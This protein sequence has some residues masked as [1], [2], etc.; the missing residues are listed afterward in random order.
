MRSE[1]I[2]F[3]GGRSFLSG[4][5]Y[6]NAIDPTTS[7]LGIPLLLYTARQYP[8]KTGDSDAKLM[9]DFVVA[10]AQ[11]LGIPFPEDSVILEEDSEDTRSNAIYTFL[12]FAERGVQPRRLLCITSSEHQSRANFEFADVWGDEVEITWSTVPSMGRI[13]PELERRLFYLSELMIANGQSP[14]YP[15]ADLKDPALRSRAMEMD[16]LRRHIIYTELIN[17]YASRQTLEQ[18]GGSPEVYR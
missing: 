1:N 13:D 5:V 12:K 6:N 18:R 10:L 3:S 8:N 14:I 11:D 2:V 15:F 16:I 7:P 9:R 4:G 17:S